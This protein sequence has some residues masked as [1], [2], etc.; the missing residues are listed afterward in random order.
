VNT[1]TCLSVSEHSALRERDFTWVS[2]ISFKDIRNH[3]SRKN[4]QKAILRNAAEIKA[5]RKSA[6]VNY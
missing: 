2:I 3:H 5:L 4:S 1:A 6:F